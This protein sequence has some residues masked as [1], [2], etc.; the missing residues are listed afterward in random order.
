MINLSIIGVL[1]D[2]PRGAAQALAGPRCGARGARGV[3]R[4]ADVAISI[5]APELVALIDALAGGGE[6]VIVCTGLARGLV[7]RAR[8]AVRK[9]AVGRHI[10]VARVLVL[11]FVS[12]LGA[13]GVAAPAVEVVRPLA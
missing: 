1:E 9:I 7:L 8:L 10:F 11:V 12:S 13:R 6:V 3:A 2:L 4:L 5:V